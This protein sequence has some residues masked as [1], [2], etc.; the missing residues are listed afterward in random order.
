MGTWGPGAFDNDD[1]LD[2]LDWL[3]R[4]TE[5]RRAQAVELI[6]REAIECRGDL[7]EWCSPREVVAAVA[8]VAAGLEPGEA[9]RAEITKCGHETSAVLIPGRSS[10]LADDALA[11]LLIAAGRDGEWHQGWSDAATARQAHLTTDQLAS[12]F[13][14]D[15]HRNDQELPLEY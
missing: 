7:S 15:Q 9:I 3:A 11:A 4:H 13:Y 10:A 6:F 5:A 2:L 8:I 1:A 14:R 12:V